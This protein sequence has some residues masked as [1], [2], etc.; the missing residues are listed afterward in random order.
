MTNNNETPLYSATGAATRGNNSGN[1]GAKLPDEAKGLAWGAYL[2]NIFWAIPNRTYIAFL[3]LVPYVGFVVGFY[4]LFKGKELAW[5]NRRWPSV[6]EFNR[7]QR[8]W[9]QWG[10]VVLALLVIAAVFL[11]LPML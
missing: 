6:E 5:Q 8:K 7:I 1:P 11:L 4:L 2:L 10:F 3:I 9:A